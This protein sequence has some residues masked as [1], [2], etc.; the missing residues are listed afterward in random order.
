MGHG[1]VLE[2]DAVYEPD[3]ASTFLRCLEYVAPLGR[4]TIISI[5]DLSGPFSIETWT[6]KDDDFS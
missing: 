1:A 6:E 4:G 5:Q 2:E 3:Y